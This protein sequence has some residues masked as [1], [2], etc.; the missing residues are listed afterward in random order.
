MF[1]GKN[2]F[3][4]SF[5]I[6]YVTIK[7]LPVSVNILYNFH[8]NILPHSTIQSKTQLEIV[9]LQIRTQYIGIDYR[10]MAT[11][12]QKRLRN[13]HYLKNFIPT[14]FVHILLQKNE[15]YFAKKFDCCMLL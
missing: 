7:V 8:C 1:F 13:L 3:P 5:S 6:T 2:F 10:L 9:K 15:F 4:M 11:L 14:A 12:L